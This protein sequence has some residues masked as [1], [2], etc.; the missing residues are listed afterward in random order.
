MNTVSIYTIPLTTG[1]GTTTEPQALWVKQTTAGT[2]P[3]PAGIVTLQK[4]LDCSFERPIEVKT[5]VS[6]FW[7]WP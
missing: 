7:R 3:V 2:I 5:P 1:S 6:Q 4:D